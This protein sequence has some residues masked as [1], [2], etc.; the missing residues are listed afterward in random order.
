ML[1]HELAFLIRGFKGPLAKTLALTANI[2]DP[3]KPRYNLGN[4]VF[5]YDS[6]IGYS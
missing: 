6:R 2:R 4:D 5:L 1:A 3:T